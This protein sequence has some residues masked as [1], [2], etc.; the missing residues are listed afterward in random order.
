MRPYLDPIS[1]Q[2]M[3]Y[4]KNRNR[5]LMLI[6][7]LFVILTKK[8]K[9]K[10]NRLTALSRKSVTVKNCKHSNFLFA[11]KLVYWILFLRWNSL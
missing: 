2:S 1:Q 4:M 3:G 5:S 10:G 8:K 7:A 6:I 11:R 9:K